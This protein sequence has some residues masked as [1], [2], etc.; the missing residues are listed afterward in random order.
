MNIDLNVPINQQIPGGIYLVFASTRPSELAADSATT[1]DGRAAYFCMTPDETCDGSNVHRAWTMQDAIMV[2]M[3]PSEE[4]HESYNL[5]HW[6]PNNAEHATLV[7]PLLEDRR[8]M[9]ATLMEGRLRRYHPHM[10]L[11]VQAAN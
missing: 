5:I 9:L 6:G 4:E 8:N 10:T 3:R 2:A 1:F 11:Y 7:G